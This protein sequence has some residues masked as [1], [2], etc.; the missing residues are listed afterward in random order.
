MGSNGS[1]ETFNLYYRIWEMS[2]SLNH[3][4][5]GSQIQ[6]KLPT[7]TEVRLLRGLIWCGGC[8]F[9]VALLLAAHQFYISHTF[10]AHLAAAGVDDPDAVF[11]RGHILIIPLLVL[12]MGLSLVGLIV[13][14][15]GWMVKR[16]EHHVRARRQLH[17]WLNPQT[18]QAV[19]S[20]RSEGP[21]L[22]SKSSARGSED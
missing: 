16:F 6:T 10:A 14:G 4:A 21:S 22:N 11:G 8:F 15:I 3:Q 9:V 7:G 13:C 1:A 5:F 20:N 17:Q 2:K 18:E 19:P 12:P